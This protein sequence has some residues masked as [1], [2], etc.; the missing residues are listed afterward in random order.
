[1]EFPRYLSVTEDHQ[2]ALQQVDELLALRTQQAAEEVKPHYQVHQQ[3]PYYQAEVHSPPTFHVA[4]SFENDDPASSC[5]F[6]ASDG[7]TATSVDEQDI[8]GEELMLHC[9]EDTECVL[10]VVVVEHAMFGVEVKE[11]EDVCKE[12]VPV[13]DK[14]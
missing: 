12:E 1:M 2:V 8:T 3:N 11:V 10:V 7:V 14:V 4:V 13:A 5:A 6:P 9:G